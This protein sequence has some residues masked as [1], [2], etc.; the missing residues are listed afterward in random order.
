MFVFSFWLDCW[1]LDFKGYAKHL[2]MSRKWAQ[3]I[4][5]FHTV[6]HLFPKFAHWLKSHHLVMILPCMPISMASTANLSPEF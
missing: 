2:A 4:A 3:S 5:A 1:V 6:D